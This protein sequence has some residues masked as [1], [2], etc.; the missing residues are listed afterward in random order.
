[1]TERR[2]PNPFV[3][4]GVWLALWWGAVALT[5]MVLGPPS[6]AAAPSCNRSNPVSPRRAALRVIEGGRR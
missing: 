2:E 1:M 3:T 6:R 4:F 5:A